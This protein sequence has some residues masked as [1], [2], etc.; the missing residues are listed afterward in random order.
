MIYLEN[1]WY[2]RKNFFVFRKK[3]GMTGKIFKCPFF[4]KSA[5]QS[6]APQLFE[7]SYAPGSHRYEN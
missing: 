2:F 6:L 4:S 1:F 3:C 7:A 5:L